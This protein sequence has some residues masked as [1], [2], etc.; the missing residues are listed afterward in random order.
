MTSHLPAEK[1]WLFTLHDINGD[2]VPELIIWESVVSFFFAAHSVYTFFDGE[3]ELLEIAEGFGGNP[4]SL[5]I[6]SRH[7]NIPG[8]IVSGSGELFR[9]YMLVSMEG[10]SLSIDICFTV[11]T[12]P[13]VRGYDDILYYIRGLHTVTTKL[14]VFLYWLEEEHERM[15]SE[16]YVL[17]SELVFYKLHDAVFGFLPVSE[18]PHLHPL[19]GVERVITSWE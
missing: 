5:S 1:G 7:D 16:G 14:P 17:V 3:A 11:T 9:R 18:R 6:F 13:W 15:I 4:A 8:I 2:G 12:L 19:T 10:N